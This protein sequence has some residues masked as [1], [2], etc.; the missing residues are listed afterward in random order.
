MEE[1]EQMLNL[2]LK[3]ETLLKKNDLKKKRVKPFWREK[4]QFWVL[5]VS[6]SNIMAIR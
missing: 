4:G 2:D 1:D 5:Y 3:P 6:F